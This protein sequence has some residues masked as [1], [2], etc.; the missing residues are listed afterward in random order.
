[1]RRANVT[2]RKLKVLHREFKYNILVR[3]RA[4]NLR[5]SLQL[6]LHVDKVFRIKIYLQCLG[7]VDLVSNAFANNLGGVHNVLK[8]N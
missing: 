6:S 1:M 3:E 8:L 7:T 4:I 5:K 2:T